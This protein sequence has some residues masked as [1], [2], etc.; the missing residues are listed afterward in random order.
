MLTYWL[1][2]FAASLEGADAANSPEVRI[3][4]EGAFRLEHNGPELAT[5]PFDE[6]SPI[7]LR[8]AQV[9]ESQGGRVYDLRYIGQ[10]AGTFDLRDYLVRRDGEP[11][12]D[13]PAAIVTIRESLPANHNGS[14]E[15]IADPGILGALPYRFLLKLAV[16]LWLM[17]IAFLIAHRISGRRQE[18]PS[19]EPAPPTLADQLRPLVEAA[20]A[21]EMSLAEK[22]RLERLLFA[23]WRERLEPPG[24][25]PLEL[26]RRMK[27]H[28]E[29]RVLLLRLEEW[30]HQRPKPRP[31][32][33]A[34]LLAPY[35]SAQAVELREPETEGVPA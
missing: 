24:L 3:G 32:D 14:L 17:G 1:C 21:G 29:A 25:S 9:T 28:A 30:L 18:A 8:I 31:H 10:Y 11:L 16:G 19:E 7:V 15:E 35:R 5:K 4:I 22:G 33:L 6:K 27:E 23:Y 2:L 34:E 13:V 12:E 26:L 20:I